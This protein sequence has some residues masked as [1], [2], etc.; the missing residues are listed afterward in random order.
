MPL[1]TGQP[2]VQAV[3]PS[4]IRDWVISLGEYVKESE[5]SNAFHT[6][7]PSTN[8]NSE[9]SVITLDGSD[10]CYVLPNFY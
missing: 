1:T 3:N 8:G 7:M 4:F 9:S 2:L 10:Q 6:E 5:L